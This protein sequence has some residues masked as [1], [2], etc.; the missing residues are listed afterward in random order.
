[1]P[2]AFLILGLL[3]IALT[4]LACCGMATDYGLTSLVYFLS[5]VVLI[6]LEIGLGAYWVN[7]QT[8][9]VPGF[10][11][12]PATE[13]ANNTFPSTYKTTLTTLQYEFD[14]SLNDYSTDSLDSISTVMESSPPTTEVKT[15]TPPSPRRRKVMAA[16]AVDFRSFEHQEEWRTMQLTF[17]CCGMNGAK[18]F[19]DQ[20]K[21]VPPEC[22]KAKRT[23]EKN[24]TVLCELTKNAQ[25]GCLE[26]LLVRLF[27]DRLIL[28][29]LSIIAGSLTLIMLVTS[30]F[31]RFDDDVNSPGAELFEGDE[32]CGPTG[33]RR[34]SAIAQATILPGPVQLCVPDQQQSPPCC[35]KYPPCQCAPKLRQC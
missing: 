32:F 20:G 12:T 28:G 4:I 1:M 6:G 35:R 17:K 10:F 9:F 16:S 19:I 25:Q 21:G 24:N 14:Y 30:F 13:L 3:T 11:T 8:L 7:I 33:C 15:T 22:C 2:M 23:K 26:A 18:D 5:I 27:V 31:I 34:E 29:S